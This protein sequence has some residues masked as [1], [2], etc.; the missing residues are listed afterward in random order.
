MGFSDAQ[1]PVPGA[2]IADPKSAEMIRAWIAKQGLH[3]SL[4]IGVWGAD[5]GV[6]ERK[7]WGILLADVARHV[8]NALATEGVAQADSVAL[9]RD[10]FLGE[11]DSPTSGASGDFVEGPSRN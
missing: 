11:L 7:A 9:I 3:C 8:A 4:N 1:L 5:S 2:A 10:S 6:D